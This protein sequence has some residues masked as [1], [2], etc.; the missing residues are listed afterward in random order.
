MLV[1]ISKVTDFLRKTYPN[2]FRVNEDLDYVCEVMAQNQQITSPHEKKH[3]RFTTDGTEFI[4]LCVGTNGYCSGTKKSIFTT[5]D[6]DF[7]KRDGKYAHEFIE[8]L[9]TLEFVTVFTSTSGLGYHIYVPLYR[10]TK[11]ESKLE[12]EMLSLEILL[13]MCRLAKF[14]FN[15]RMDACG[16]H[17]WIFNTKKADKGLVKIKTAEVGFTL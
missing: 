5:Y 14:P 13:H 2:D 15:R 4:P 1:K 3:L 16:R 12:H 10:E 9:K 6:I 17:L 8:A 7:T 11:T